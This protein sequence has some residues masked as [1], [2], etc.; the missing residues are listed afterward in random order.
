M[1]HQGAEHVRAEEDRPQAP[2]LRRRL[3]GERC[4]TPR[5]TPLP[6]RARPG[7][8]R[9]MPSR[10]SIVEQRALVARWRASGL[11]LT[12]FS[13]AKYPL[14]PGISSPRNRRVSLMREP[15][16]LR[17]ELGDAAPRVVEEASEDINE[18]CVRIDALHHARADEGVEVGGGQDSA[19]IVL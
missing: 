14:T 2:E 8:A 1:V 17:R 18:G 13:R 15:P 19:L 11:S 5:R 7:S 9:V 6:R 16:A 4:V 3:Q 10:L 12:A